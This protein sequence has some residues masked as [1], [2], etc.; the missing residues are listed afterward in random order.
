MEVFFKVSWVAW[1][2]QGNISKGLF[3]FYVV[4][5]IVSIPLH[6]FTKIYMFSFSIL[7]MLFSVVFI[8]LAVIIVN[9]FVNKKDVVALGFH[10]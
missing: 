2:L 8:I 3:F 9:R 6:V 5:T 1:S 4:Q 10:N 7:D